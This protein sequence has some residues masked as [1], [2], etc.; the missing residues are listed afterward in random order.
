MTIKIYSSG[1]TRTHKI[2]VA[3]HFHILTKTRTIL[4]CID[5]MLGKDCKTNKTTT[6]ARQ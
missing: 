3:W 5:P 6:I 2:G 4:W 1:K